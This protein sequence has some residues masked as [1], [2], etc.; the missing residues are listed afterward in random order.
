MIYLM[1]PDRQLQPIS[2]QTVLFLVNSVSAHDYIII[3]IIEYHWHRQKSS[4]SDLFS[5]VEKARDAA[6]PHGIPGFL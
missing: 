1:F 5:N 4:F 2:G 6:F 3:Y